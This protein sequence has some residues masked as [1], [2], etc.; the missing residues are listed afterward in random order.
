MIMAQL[1]E[2]NPAT[3]NGAT[4]L[5]EAAD[6]GHA[7]ICRLILDS[8]EDKNPAD[9]VGDTPLHGAAR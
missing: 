6:E 7:D 5:H 2:K 3:V 8:V 9:S 1:T 4:P